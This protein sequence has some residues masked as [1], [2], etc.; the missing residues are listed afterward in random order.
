MVNASQ[1][2]YEYV[3]CAAFTFSSFITI[4]SNYKK[5]LN[6]QNGDA[7]KAQILKTLKKKKIFI[8]NNL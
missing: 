1:L 5:N 7:P 8:S 2:K 6:F 3:G 4:Q